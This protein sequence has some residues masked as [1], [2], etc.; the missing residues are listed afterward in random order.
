M[1]KRQAPMHKNSKAY[2][3]ILLPMWW[4]VVLHSFKCGLHILI[5]PK[6]TLCES[7]L[8]FYIGN[9][10]QMLGYQSNIIS[11]S[12][13]CCSYSLHMTR[14][15]SLYMTW[16]RCHL[17]VWTFPPTTH[18][19]SPFNRKTPDKSPLGHILHTTWALLLQTVRA[20][21]NSAIL[22]NCHC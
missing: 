8:W 19:C 3:E 14:Q 20:I 4:D 6:N 9:T 13:S 2:I 18:N 16:Q 5:F 7:R 12:K 10:W 1:E 22:R 11:S 15:R 21:R 17:P